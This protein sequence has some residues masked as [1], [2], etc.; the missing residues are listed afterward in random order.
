M[1]SNTHI[2]Y[3]TKIISPSS[4]SSS[5]TPLVPPVL[6]TS[7]RSSYCSYCFQTLPLHR[8]KHPRQL[9]WH[10]SSICEQKDTC[11]KLE[12]AVTHIILK[13]GG[14][15]PTT[16]SLLLLRI[17]LKLLSEFQG[18]VSLSLHLH[19]QAQL[20]SLTSNWDAFTMKEHE[21]FVAIA[22]LVRMM[23]YQMNDIVSLVKKPYSLQSC[24][25]ALDSGV[26]NDDDYN[27]DYNND[28]KNDSGGI[29]FISRLAAK[30][31]MN[32]FS[33]CNGEQ[34]SMGL[35]IYLGASMA[36]HSCQP[37]AIQSFHF[38]KGQ[39]PR[40]SFTACTYIKVSSN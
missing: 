33:I 35:G 14:H 2:E 20:Q 25:Q 26:D 17:M 11:W 22:E 7:N 15:V 24:L 21:H 38:D 12:E 28:Y 37:N 31:S 6:H 23:L 27:N 30:I 29:D 9:H 16:L 19:L 10:C 18:N 5:S 3:G 32:G 4:S 36:N 39:T 1:I 34:I 8:L 40:L 13:R